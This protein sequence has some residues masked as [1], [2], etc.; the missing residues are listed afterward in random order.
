MKIQRLNEKNEKY[1]II[2][3]GLSDILPKG[4]VKMEYID[5]SNN[6]TL[7]KIYLDNKLIATEHWNPA[8]GKSINCYWLDA[9]CFRQRH[10]SCEAF[11]LDFGPYSGRS[12]SMAG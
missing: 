1:D 3:D 6:L 12:I 11:V 8:I 2:L 7:V 4:K 10:P 5:K 9:F